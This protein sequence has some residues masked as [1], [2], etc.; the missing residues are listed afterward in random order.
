[1]SE[2][3]K[4]HGEKATRKTDLLIAAL[5]TESSQEAAAVKAG[6][7]ER[8]VR[9]WLRRPGFR[10]RY[11]AARREAV[12]FAVGRLQRAAAEAVDTLTANLKAKRASDRNRAAALV[13]EHANRGVE[14]ADVLERVEMIEARLE[15][16]YGKPQ[17]PTS[18]AGNGHAGHGRR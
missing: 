13:L 5:L 15:A 10:S 14:L 1:M 17:H 9:A 3:P 11:R 12:E 18:A 4:G 2:G 8:T 6:V 7:S 16:N